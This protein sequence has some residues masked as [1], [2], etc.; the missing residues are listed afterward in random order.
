MISLECQTKKKGKRKGG[1]KIPINITLTND[2]PPPANFLKN[3]WSPSFYMALMYN[4]RK[5]DIIKRRQMFVL[6]RQC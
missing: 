4:G 2:P 6:Q 1:R 3:P 5:L